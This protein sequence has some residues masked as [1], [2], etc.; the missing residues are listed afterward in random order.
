MKKTYLIET[1]KWKVIVMADSLTEAWIKFFKI[2]YDK[3]NEVKY[4]IGHVAILYDDEGKIYACRTLPTIYNLNL[5]DEK[6]AVASLSKLLE[7]DEDEAKIML[8]KVSMADMWVADG[9][10]QLIV[11]EMKEK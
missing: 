2:M 8:K 4:K 6:E 9:V 11:K 10:R 1:M 3:W 5:V 7:I